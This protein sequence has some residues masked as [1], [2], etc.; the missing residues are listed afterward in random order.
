MN[1]PARVRYAM[2]IV[3]RLASCEGSLTRD[4]IAEAEG[5]TSAYT[6]KLLHVLKRKG[7]VSTI[8][9]PKGGYVLEDRARDTTVADIFEILDDGMKFTPCDGGECERQQKC[10]MAT[11]WCGAIDAFKRELKKTTVRDLAVAGKG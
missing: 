4:T 10:P 1:I 11:V 5:I 8:R 2:R 9:G 6:D 3:A 7:L